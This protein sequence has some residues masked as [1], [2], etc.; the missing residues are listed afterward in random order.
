MALLKLSGFG[1]EIAEDFETQLKEMRTMDL[2]YIALRNLWGVNILDL[3]P[4]QM[5][6]ARDL[7]RKYGMGVS[8]IGSPIGKVKINSSW[9]QEWLRYE[10]ALEMAHYFNCPRIRIFSFYFPKND[11]AE[12]HRAM[13]VKR[14]KEMS[15]R[16]EQE[17]VVLLHENE[18]NIYGENGFRCKDLYEE[19][20]SP[21]FQLIFD[22]ANY[23]FVGQKPYTQWYDMQKDYVDRKSVV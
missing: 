23:V 4:Q 11:P 2:N 10:K 15:D 8:E 19:V 12:K 13:V 21:N 9:K 14:L 20:G 7:L 18:A 5:K 17:G 3:S 6:R 16:A 22:P 1:D